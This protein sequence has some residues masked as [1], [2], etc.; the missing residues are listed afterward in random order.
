MADTKRMEWTVSSMRIAAKAVKYK[1]IRLLKG[2]L[3]AE[4]SNLNCD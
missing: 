4:Q 3:L 1:K 2:L